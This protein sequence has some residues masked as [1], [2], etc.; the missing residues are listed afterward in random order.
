M[1]FL[2]VGV[3]D[4]CL[5]ASWKTTFNHAKVT[6]FSPSFFSFYSSDCLFIFE[7]LKS[8]VSFPPSQLRS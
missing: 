4:E 2:S 1:T 7:L 5:I 3:G 6:S 8:T